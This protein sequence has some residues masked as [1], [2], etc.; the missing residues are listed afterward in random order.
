MSDRLCFSSRRS[1]VV[2]LSACVASSQTLA[3]SAGLDIL[4]QGG[5]A[6]DAAVAVAAALAVTEPCSTGLGGDAFCLFY[7]AHTKEIQGLNG[8]GRAAEAQSLDFMEG[9]GFTADA[10]PPPFDALNV[11]VPGAPA[12]W[13][14][15]LQLFGSHKLPVQDVL[16]RAVELAEGGFPVAEVTA[17]HWGL[18]VSELQKAGRGLDPDLLIQG[19][20]PKSGQVFR[21]P[22]LAQTLRELGEGG[23]PAFYE[24]RVAK[25]IVDVIR[26][27]GGVMT[28]DDLKRH[29]SEVICPISIQYKG[30][31]LWEPPPNGQGLSALLL[32][33]ILDNFPLKV[34]GHNSADY[35]H[36]F[37]EAVRLAQ[38]DVLCYL[39]DPGHVTVPVD[40]LLDK[41]YGRL[42]AQ[43][44][45]M[46]RVMDDVKPGLETGSDTV[47]FCV[48]DS[49]GNACS[50]VNSNYMG[51]GSVLVPKDCG[52]TLQNRGANFSLLRGHP[53]CISEGKRPYHTILCA[54]L[55][56]SDTQELL[57]ALGVMGAFMQPQGHVQVLLNMVE[58]EMNPQQALDAPRVYVHYD[59]KDG[60]WMVNLEEGVDSEVAEELRRRGHTVNYPVTGHKRAQFGR[61][62]IITV[63]DWWDSTVS[64]TDRPIQRVLW[65]GSDPRADGCAQGY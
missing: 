1:P 12:C 34:K 45:S 6:A 60:Q 55:T 42:R 20:A 33:N 50:F 3:T 41:S 18:W 32:L 23:K 9:R 62:Q 22:A 15:T 11:T 4:R 21:N 52:F 30:V 7:N 53:N 48:I 17:H 36:I 31:T 2:T 39:G 8:S 26:E 49:E 40:A 61:G 37:T 58:F 51:F 63:G 47:Y 28:E 27:N 24:G 10:P 59:Q 46:D 29:S 54:L 14:D 16:R 64:Q 57:A 44:I 19:R 65:A 56:H 13:C 25:A 5:N 38:T 35:I 43:S